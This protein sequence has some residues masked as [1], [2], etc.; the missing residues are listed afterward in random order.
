[1]GVGLLYTTTDSN[2]NYSLGGTVNV[3]RLAATQQGTAFSQ[4]SL[5][6]GRVLFS[7]PGTAC[8]Y[9]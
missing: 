5:V 2:G 8:R 9:T 7:L 1:M 6:A 4:P 3:I